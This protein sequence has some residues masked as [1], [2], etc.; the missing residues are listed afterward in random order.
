[1]QRLE[2]SCA[3]RHIYTYVVSRLRVKE[4]HSN[5]LREVVGDWAVLQP[6]GDSVEMRGLIQNIWDKIYFGK[7]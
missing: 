2:V 6:V 1:M 3:V 4:E 5:V 7:C